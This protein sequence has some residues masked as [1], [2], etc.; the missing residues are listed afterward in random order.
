MSR[1]DHVEIPRPNYQ[2]IE[3]P[4]DFDPSYYVEPPIEIP[5][6]MIE[7]NP[8]GIIENGKPAVSSHTSFAEP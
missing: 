6:D 2:H 5:G 3:P 7:S 8:Y 1:P 4:V